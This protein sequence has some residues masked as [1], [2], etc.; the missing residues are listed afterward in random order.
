MTTPN[1]HQART[2]ASI[3]PL[4]GTVPGPVPAVPVRAVLAAATVK[5]WRERS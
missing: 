4:A 3:T 2:L 1:A 5:L